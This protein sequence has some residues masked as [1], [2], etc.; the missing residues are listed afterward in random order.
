MKSLYAR[1][2]EDE[3]LDFDDEAS[4]GD[5]DGGGE[6]SPEPSSADSGGD[7]DFGGS[8]SDFGGGGDEGFDGVDSEEGGDEDSAGESEPEEEP[9]KPKDSIETEAEVSAIQSSIDGV[10]DDALMASS[11]AASSILGESSIF[12]RIFEDEPKSDKSVQI[13]IEAFSSKIAN[14]M[15]NYTTILDI[16]SLIYQSARK[17][18]EKDYGQD[19]VDK[20]DD[21]ISGMELSVPIGY[22]SNG[23]VSTKSIGNPVSPQ[24]VATGNVFVTSTGTLSAGT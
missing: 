10:I 8:D 16:P 22:G 2:F 11:L 24:N 6:D 1:I 20:F 7:F 23:P 9:Q 14:L 4:G 21:I 18:L 5:S 3:D 12:K 15:Q 17:R 13:D 19:W